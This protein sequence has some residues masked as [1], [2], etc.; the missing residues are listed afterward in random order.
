MESIIVDGTDMYERGFGKEEEKP[1]KTGM[2]KVRL[3]RER[4][5]LK[6]ESCITPVRNDDKR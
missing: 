5:F 4:G 1:A 3:L 6:A 2:E